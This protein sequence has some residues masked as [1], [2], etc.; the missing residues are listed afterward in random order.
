M[1]LF[2]VK[3][4]IKIKKRT[5][6]FSYYFHVIF[7]AFKSDISYLSDKGRGFQYLVCQGISSSK[8]LQHFPQRLRPVAGG[9]LSCYAKSQ[10]LIPVY[11][12]N[13]VF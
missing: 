7:V 6:E 13:T 5:S 1:S 4:F 9:K 11:D 12:V 3:I 10:M 2:N 8:K